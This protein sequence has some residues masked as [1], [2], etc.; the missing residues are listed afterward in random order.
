MSALLI[1]ALLYIADA[2]SACL[3]PDG[4][5]SL[6]AQH[7]AAP[8]QPFG[9]PAASQQPHARHTPQR[10]QGIASLHA[11]SPEVVK[12]AFPIAVKSPSAAV[13][14]GPTKSSSMRLST[15]VAAQAGPVLSN[16]PLLMDLQMSVS[17]T[18]ISPVQL[19]AQSTST[20]PVASTADISSPI[21]LAPAA[22][23]AEAPTPTL[24]PKAIATGAA[25]VDSHKSISL[26]SSTGHATAGQSSAAAATAGPL[27]SGS[28]QDILSS[29][30]QMNLQ[31]KPFDFTSQAESSGPAAVEHA[32]TPP[33]YHASPDSA[34][35]EATP[36]Q[37]PQQA[38]RVPVQQ[39]PMVVGHSSSMDLGQGTSAGPGR[40]QRVA[41]AASR[42]AT[43]IEQA[44]ELAAEDS[45]E[46]LPVGYV[47]RRTTDPYMEKKLR[48]LQVSSM[49]LS[50]LAD[51]DI[52]VSLQCCCNTQIQLV[53]LC[54]CFLHILSEVSLLS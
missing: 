15:P 24:V 21:A 19:N 17:A 5:T 14:T 4:P 8:L 6:G 42:Q 16:T 44:A 35:Q 38:L 32:Q 29:L 34:D 45:A 28:P 13:G 49:L 53:G 25:P 47:S 22:A 26:D 23:N 50:L 48:S 46:A 39:S 2:S 18:A 7:T 20:T 43:E 11:M 33:P 40:A 10:S 1:K 30:Q 36:V 12:S 51:H 31:S 54:T 27:A 9:M 3:Q 41:V 37:R 52:T